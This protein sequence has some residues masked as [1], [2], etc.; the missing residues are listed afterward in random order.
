MLASSDVEQQ[1]EGLVRLADEANTDV[2]TSSVPL[3]V[4]L[5]SDSK[6]G[7][8]QKAAVLLLSVKVTPDETAMQA[9]VRDIG[10]CNEAVRG[11]LRQWESLPD[12]H[13]SRCL[14]DLVGQECAD[15]RDW[16]WK[17]VEEPT[18]ELI[19]GTGFYRWVRTE[20]AAD[21]G[22]RL[23]QA[24]RAARQPSQKV[25]IAL[26]VLQDKELSRSTR[27][28]LLAVMQD[29]SLSSSILLECATIASR[30]SECL[31]SDEVTPVAATR[32]MPAQV[33]MAL[34]RGVEK[35][36][37]PDEF[38]HTVLDIL[39]RQDVPEPVR[40]EALGFLENARLADELAIARL[41]LSAGSSV[42]FRTSIVGVLESLLQGGSSFEERCAVLAEQLAKGQ[43]PASEEVVLA[44]RSLLLNG[45]GF[46]REYAFEI[47]RWLRPFRDLSD[48]VLT[49]VP[50]LPYIVVEDSFGREGRDK[51]RTMEARYA[52]GDFLFRAGLNDH[53]L[54]ILEDILDYPWKES[55][56][57]L[58]TAQRLAAEGHVQAVR[59]LLD[60]IRQPKESWGIQCLGG[61]VRSLILAGEKMNEQDKK[62][63]VGVAEAVRTV[64]TP[65]HRSGWPMPRGPREH[66]MLMMANMLEY[67]IR[68]AV[69]T[70]PAVTGIEA[71]AELLKDDPN[72][73]YFQ[74][75]R[76]ASWLYRFR[77]GQPGGNDR[78]RAAIGSILASTT[79]YVR[80]PGYGMLGDFGFKKD[81]GLL[82]KAQKKEKKKETVATIGTA[83]TNLE[84]GTYRGS[85]SSRARLRR[86][87][88]I[89]T[90]PWAG[91]SLP[92]RS[93]R[94][95]WPRH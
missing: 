49:L 25:E 47:L 59:L 86:T 30:G 40:I 81:L 29:M 32:G 38:R 37:A 82:R 44:Y 93:Q 64:A 71:C 84:S 46:E 52:V 48:G 69:P 36:C 57:P 11:V 19:E 26:K 43:V 77:E 18:N 78:I 33:V 7:I 91:T 13:R 22:I 70:A 76:V 94:R 51:K 73:L 92:I 5:L 34:L 42:D 21:N 8:A 2:K 31:K 17:R 23:V 54:P 24:L 61:T 88:L 63:V 56:R 90:S 72:D 83:I 39:V 3:L 74:V 79:D 66:V 89:P 20:S 55:D 4:K 65:I 62:Q 10:T 12:Q 53:A 67:G 58:F 85:S 41:A 80:E 15:I 9:A 68:A 1:Q 6:A 28:Q 95:C 27:V 16:L 14:D 75:L 60:D 87:A 50:L 35:G 45:T